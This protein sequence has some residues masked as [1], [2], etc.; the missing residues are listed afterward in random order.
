MYFTEL[1][2]EKGGFS[3]L[4]T[5]WDS[6]GQNE[7]DIVSIDSFEKSCT[8]Y[9]VKRNKAKY[10]SEKLAYKTEIFKKN[11]PGFRTELIGL[12]IEDM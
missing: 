11:I 9:E 1:L 5:W 3:M 2:K 7:I 4:G 12:S 6:K 8:L 10:N